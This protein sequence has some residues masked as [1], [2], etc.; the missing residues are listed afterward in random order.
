[1]KDTKTFIVVLIIKVVSILVWRTQ[2]QY[3]SYTQTTGI[4]PQ[5]VSCVPQHEPDRH[6]GPNWE[7][8]LKVMVEPVRDPGRVREYRIFGCSLF[9]YH[10][11]FR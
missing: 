3:P 8:T 5:V 6:T 1:M 10:Q 4:F 2:A 7:P 11:Y 9:Y